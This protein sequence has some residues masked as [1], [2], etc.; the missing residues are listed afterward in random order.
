[1]PL[2]K[3]GRDSG[4]C[5][6]EDTSAEDQPGSHS[7]ENRGWQRQQECGAHDRTSHAGGDDRGGDP[8]VFP[9]FAP[10]AERPAQSSGHHSDGVRRVGNH[11]GQTNRQKNREAQ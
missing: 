2:A 7:L 3:Q 4:L 8:R 6:D 1:M 11:G 9:K 5:A 10:V